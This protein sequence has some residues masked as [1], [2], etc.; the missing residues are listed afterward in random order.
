MPKKSTE[1]KLTIKRGV[2]PPKKPVTV[3]GVLGENGLVASKLG[4]YEFRPQQVEM[5][6]AV[7]DALCKKQILIVE[8]AT[9]TGKTLAYLVPSLLS[10]RRV[11]ISTGTKALQEQLFQKDIPFLASHWHR[12]VKAVL[13]KGRRNYLCKMRLEEMTLNPKFRASSDVQHWPTI[14]EWA[15]DTETGDRADVSGLPDDF[16]TWADLSVGSE[17]C[18]GSRCAHY[19]SCFVTKARKQASEAELIVVNHHLFFADLA[20]KQGGFGEVIPEH[21]AV[22]FDEAHHLE[23]IASNYFGMECSNWRVNELINDLTRAMESEN[24]TDDDLKVSMKSVTQR[25]TS[26][27]S[28]LAF[29]H[30]EG[31]YPLGHIINGGQKERIQ[32]SYRLFGVSLTELERELKRFAGASELSERLSERA[33]ELKFDMD[34]LMSC[35]DEKYTYFMEIRDRGV[36][37]NAAPI[38]LAELFQKKLLRDHDTIVFTSATLSTN[39]N[40]TFFKQRMG[41][42]EIPPLELPDKQEDPNSDDKEK[43]SA[44]TVKVKVKAQKPRKAAELLLAPVFDYEDQ[45]L[46]YVPRRLPP[47]NSPKF[48]EG[49]AQIVEYLVEIT[50]GRAFVLFTSWANMNAT[51]ELLE[52]KLPYTVFK[53][54]TRPKSELLR[55]FKEDEHSVLFATSSFW[56]GVDVEGDALKLVIIDKLPFASPADPLNRARMDLLEARGKSS[57]NDFSVP[58]AALML[59]QGFGR[60]I[61]SRSDTGVVAILDSRIATKRYG[62]H[63]IKSLPPAPVVWNASDVKRWWQDKFGEPE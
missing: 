47:P 61:R 28:M 58:G 36:F 29:G 20:L 34:A 7:Y 11:V 43:K 1:K 48:I 51:F 52:D 45:C 41:L 23:E 12:E 50:Q 27:F 56:E 9:G 6:N 8:A 30:Y 4:R 18:K 38:D 54:G 44:E 33:A 17:A 37:L 57:F 13:L 62:S 16:P 25:A 2:K 35:D 53:Q 59:K 55:A 63:F 31:R 40:F 22:V 14:K 26:F 5:G 32:E 46:V 3:D 39:D 10:G 21:D 24:A 49:V 60:L 19:E 15:K 42:E